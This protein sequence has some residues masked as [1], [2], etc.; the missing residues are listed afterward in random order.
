MEKVIEVTRTI[1]QRTPQTAS[2]KTP[3]KVSKTTTHP[4][5]P[6]VEFDENGEPIGACTV[7]ELFDELDR[8]FV[9]F[10]G[11]EGRQMVNARRKEWNQK[12]TWHFDLF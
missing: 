10:Y 8:K 2:I 1:S 9:D 7:V 4:A 12:G 11:E 6:G 3:E 5:H